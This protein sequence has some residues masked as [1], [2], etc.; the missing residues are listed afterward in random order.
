MNR[1]I[2]TTADGS[3]T[4]FV[5][6]LGQH[7]HSTHGAL[8]ESLHIFIKA[9]LHFIAE[10]NSKISILEVGFGTGLNAWLTALEAERLC[11]KIHYEGLEKYPL[12]EAEYSSF[13]EN[14][15]GLEEVYLE[16]VPLLGGGAEERGGGG[17]SY[18][19]SPDA[20]RH[21]LGERDNARPSD[22]GNHNSEILHKIHQSAWQTPQKISENFTLQKFQ[23]DLK[24]FSAQKRFDLIYFDAF[25]PSAQ[26]DLWTETIFQK[27]YDALKD[28]GVLVTYCVKGDVRRAMKKASFR[29]DKIAGPPGKR[30]MARAVK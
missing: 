25:A 10:K 30:E 26:P 14:F 15:V 24:D 20:A 8:Q 17:I 29:V 28:G 12:L 13:I 1:K 6:D 3:P 16:D 11:L 19:S 2:E 18:I 5:P 23:I 22:I 27:M 9:G 21:P 4:F 7:Y